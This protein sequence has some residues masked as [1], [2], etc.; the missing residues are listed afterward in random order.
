MSG[1]SSIRSRYP[2][3]NPKSIAESEFME[4]FEKPRSIATNDPEE[5]KN[6]GPTL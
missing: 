3:L 1:R 2:R 6:V 4:L 5:L